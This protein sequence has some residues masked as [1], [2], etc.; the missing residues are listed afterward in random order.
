MRALELMND[1]PMPPIYLDHNA[2]T[3]VHPEVF[4]AMAPYLREGFGNPS[5]AHIYGNRA[6]VAVEQA[7]AAVAGLL[8]CSPGEVVFTSG[9]TESNNLAIRGTADAHRN[10][11][12]IVTSV[13]EHPATRLPCRHLA[14]QG[15]AVTWIPVDGTGMVDPDEVRPFVRGDTLLVTVM[16]ANNETG[17]IM[18][19][20]DIARTAHE[21]GALVHTD[22]AQAVGKIPVSVDELDVDLLSIAGHKLYAPKGIGALYVRYGTAVS[23]I[24]LGGGQ[25]KGLSPGTE[26]VPYIV[27]LGRACELAAQDMELEADRQRTLADRLWSLLSAAVPGLR[28]NGHPERRLPNTLNIAFPD[29]SGSSLL[30]RADRLAASTGSACHEGGESPSPVLLEMGLTPADALG[31]VRLSVGRFTT[32]EEVESAAGWLLAA[33]RELLGR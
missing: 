21:R 16:L 18:P 33:Y 2:T 10:K 29:V 30:A 23:P 19:L 13:V 20:A 9:G 25:E 3:P 12:H 31:A 22:A 8:G 11:R 6:R 15:M 5:S 26:N 4:E 24:L 7:R 14:E 27:G 17:T 28:L 32:E 1:S